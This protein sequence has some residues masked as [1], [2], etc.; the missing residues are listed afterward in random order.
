MPKAAAIMRRLACAGC[1]ML[2]LLS[3]TRAQEPDE[4][5]ASRPA[6]SIVID[7][8]G[9]NLSAGLRAIELP[10]AIAYAFLPHT[11]HAA[12]LARLAHGSGKEVM[13]HAP[14]ESLQDN[15]LLGPG[16]FTVEMSEREFLRTL[17]EDLAAVPHVTGINNH[18]GSLLTRHP[19]HMTWL[20]RDLGRRGGL[21]FVDSL[22]TE[23]SVAARIAGEHGVPALRRDIFLDAERDAGHVLGQFYRLLDHAHRHGYAL[24]IGHPYPETLQVLR[25]M[26]PRLESFN[27][28]LIPLSEQFNRRASPWQAS[29][30]P[31]PRAAKSSKP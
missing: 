1:L 8:I 19:G 15:H 17:D 10:G 30:S 21:F 4:I 5:R 18:M 31:S 7:D 23:S 25:N 28:R 22:T 9:Y 26:L 13:L 12:E 14:M 16:A 11:P 3:S 20:M 2:G 27:V 29:L 24:G 6:I